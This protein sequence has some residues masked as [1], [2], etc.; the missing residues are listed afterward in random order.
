MTPWIFSDSEGVSLFLHHQ[1]WWTIWL[2]RKIGLILHC[3]QTF[4]GAPLSIRSL[5]SSYLQRKFAV[6]SINAYYNMAQQR[7][8]GTWKKKC[9]RQININNFQRDAATFWLFFPETLTY[10]PASLQSHE[11]CPV[12]RLW[13]Y[14]SPKQFHYVSISYVDGSHSFW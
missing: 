2:K 11:K 8:N 1:T 12:K 4:F 9:W 14:Q 13:T 10:I 5:Y 7:V 6:W 3:T